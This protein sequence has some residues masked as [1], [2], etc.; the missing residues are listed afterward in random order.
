MGSP[1][2]ITRSLVIDAPPDRLHELVDD[3]HA[4][5]AWSPWEDLDPNLE[6]S[7]SGPES[8]LG[9][10]YAWKGNKR[11]GSGSMEITGLAPDRVD[12]RLQFTAPWQAD[13]KVALVFTPAQAGG[14]DVTW[15]MSGEHV[16]GFRGLVMKLMPMDRML[17][18]DFEKGLTRLK[19]L[20]EA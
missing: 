17:G 19:G 9:A 4:W 6:R 1:F 10:H 2:T 16:G 5:R 12:I 18:R 8:G 13:N 15:T 7:Y 11:A 14:T 20:S 3:F